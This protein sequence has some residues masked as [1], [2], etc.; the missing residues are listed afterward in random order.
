MRGLL[1]HVVNS[2]PGFRVSGAARNVWDAKLEL[3]R[4]RPDLVILDEVLPGESSYDLLLEARGLEIPVILV[5]GIENP[6]HP[7]SE[8]AMDRL[9]KPTWDTWVE[10]QKRFQS[11]FV[12]V[13]GK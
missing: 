13:F 12:R 1:E 4:R 11:A 9:V 6:E 5:T 2:M 10:D 3:S 7:L 8:G